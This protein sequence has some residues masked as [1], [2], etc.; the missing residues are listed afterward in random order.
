MFAPP[1]K[2]NEEN[3]RVKILRILKIDNEMVQIKIAI[4]KKIYI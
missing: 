4:N 3:T 1:L 2:S